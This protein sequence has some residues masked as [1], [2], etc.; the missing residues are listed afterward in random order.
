MKI[1]QIL[2]NIVRVALLID[3]WTCLY[4]Y[5][6]V[7]WQRSIRILGPSAWTGLYKRY[8]RPIVGIRDVCFMENDY[9]RVLHE[10]IE[11]GFRSLYPLAILQI[12]S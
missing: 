1:L 3:I 4:N 11:Q 7:G 6:G 5:V 8:R 12:Q 9:F 10:D 2:P